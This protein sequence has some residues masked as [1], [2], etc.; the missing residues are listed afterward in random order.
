MDQ[1][2]TFEQ[3]ADHIDVRFERFYP[4]PLETVW[5]AL[6][7]PA[8]LADWMGVSTIEPRVGGRFEMMADGPHP[9]TGSVLAW[10]PPRLLELAWSNTHAPQSVVRYEL[11][12]EGRGT[13]LV[14]THRGMPYVNS[15]LMLPGWHNF[16]SR[17]ASVLEGVPP[18]SGPNYREMQAVY[19][20]RY[21]LEGVALTP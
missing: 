6:T 10:E 5:S 15:A 13:R 17:L 3:T 21:R 12:P 11:S 8:R 16:L 20:D 9:A 2:G 4:R 19:I 7:E 1:L 14:L 18:G